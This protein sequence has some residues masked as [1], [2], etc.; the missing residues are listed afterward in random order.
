M[1]TPLCSLLWLLPSSLIFVREPFW[2]HPLRAHWGLGSSPVWFLRIRCGIVVGSAL[3]IVV[4]GLVGGRG[5]LFVPS[6]SM[7]LLPDLGA[8]LIS[9]LSL[10]GGEALG[11]CAPAG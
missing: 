3:A 11:C 9:A 2:P 1:L 10:R 5:P 6:R 8:H 7:G 4:R